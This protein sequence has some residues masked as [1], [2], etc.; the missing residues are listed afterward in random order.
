MMERTCKGCGEWAICIDG[1]CG[2]CAPVS[3]VDAYVTWWNSNQGA[4]DRQVL[5]EQLLS[6]LALDQA[7]DGEPGDAEAPP[8]QVNK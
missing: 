2:D 5:A 8:G 7:R 3:S 6:K 4:I 1:Y